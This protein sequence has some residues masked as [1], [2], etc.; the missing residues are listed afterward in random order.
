LQHALI[1]RSSATDLLRNLAF[2]CLNRL[3]TSGILDGNIPTKHIETEGKTRSSSF[4]SVYS[5]LNICYGS[6]WIFYLNDQPG[7]LLISEA[8]GDSF[9]RVVYIPEHSFAVLIKV[10]CRQQTW[11]VGTW[12]SYT[13]PPV[14]PFLYNQRIYFGT[15]HM[16]ER[17]LK[18]T[19]E[20]KKFI[21][22][23]YAD[24]EGVLSE[25]NGCHVL[26]LLSI[27]KRLPKPVW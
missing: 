10:A 21:D 19:L 12:Y 22:S 4:V 5:F 24:N 15:D 23:L 1:Q 6:G 16:A 11:H 27:R 26:F 9:L 3:A 25:F 8:N 2:V 7:I 17:D 14:S 18:L 13:F 20:R